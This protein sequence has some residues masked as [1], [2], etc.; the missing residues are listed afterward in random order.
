MI[1]LRFGRA[2]VE[3]VLGRK[4]EGKLGEGKTG[5][6]LE[7]LAVRITLLKTEIIIEWRKLII[8]QSS[9]DSCVLIS[10]KIDAM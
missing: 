4:M 8:Q 10:T 9:I 3:M 7:G 5:N 1:K 2:L 6:L